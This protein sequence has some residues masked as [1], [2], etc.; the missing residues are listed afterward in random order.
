MVD[1]VPAIDGNGVAFRELPRT[2]KIIL[3]GDPTE[4]GF[5]GAV[6]GALDIDLPLAANTS[7]QG[8]RLSALWLGP[9][10]WLLL[11]AAGRAAA[12]IE[13]LR[14]ALSGRHAAIVDIGDARCAA[15]LS[16]AAARGVLAQGCAVDLH[17][18]A[19]APGT[20]AQTRLAQAEVILHRS[21]EDGFDIYVA[22]SF[23]DYL[24]RWLADA[25]ALE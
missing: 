20:V 22:R 6:R 4:K 5:T 12:V 2:G 17:P 9:D 23:A 14:A 21:A 18:R 15:H 7:S 16:G 25:M 1:A 19:F 8:A 10:E 11:C 24:W 3:R 13:A